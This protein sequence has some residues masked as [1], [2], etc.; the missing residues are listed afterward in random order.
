MWRTRTTDPQGPNNDDQP[1]AF[2]REPPGGLDGHPSVPQNSDSW[3]TAQGPSLLPCDQTDWGR[4]EPDCSQRQSELQCRGMAKETSRRPARG[5]PRPLASRRAG[6][7]GG[8]WV[9]PPQKF[10]VPWQL[11]HTGTCGGGGRAPWLS[12]RE[13]AAA[14]APTTV[15]RNDTH[16]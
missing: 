16:S 10:G 8:R 1:A 4:W 15:R 7:G 12:C 3:G 2:W 11:Q 6:L 5:S 9:T 13:S 14:S